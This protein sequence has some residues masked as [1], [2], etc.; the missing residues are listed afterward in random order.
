MSDF[1]FSS[2]FIYFNIVCVKLIYNF[3]FT[4]I[5]LL[6]IKAV[7]GVIT[8]YNDSDKCTVTE[9]SNIT[10][11]QFASTRLLGTPPCYSPN[12]VMKHIQQIGLAKL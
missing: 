8:A 1:V 4:F 9:T 10:N 6:T 3:A 5:R 2:Y 12:S 7:I 11:E